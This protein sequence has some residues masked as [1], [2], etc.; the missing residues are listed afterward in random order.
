MN[1]LVSNDD[2]I[3]ASGLHALAAALAKIGRVTVAAP[4][5]EQSATGHAITMHEPLRALPISIGI[6]DVEAY[7]VRGTPADCIKLAVDILMK[8][9]PDI[10]FSGINRG[11][12]LGTDVI[13]SGTVSAAIEAAI[14]DISAVAMSL[15]SYEY[16]NYN[17]AADLAADI[18]QAFEH[19][20]VSQQF[21]LN[22]NVPPVSRDD[23]K[24]ISITHLGIKR[25]KNNYEQ[26]Y[27]PRGRPYYWLTGELREEANDE[28][29]DIAAINRGYISI[30]PMHYDLT[31]Y[32][33]IDTL[34]GWRINEWII[35]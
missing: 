30:T 10:V 26:R 3:N 16:T 24:G 9:R 27:D 34:R 35:K 14:F 29:S 18:C 1:I 20:A 31:R 7:A 11:A 21:L 15:T 12:N 8:D 32:D 17:V 6:P 33:M 19:H 28:A 5:R 22:V 2:G 25:Y 4:D 13:Y 23:I